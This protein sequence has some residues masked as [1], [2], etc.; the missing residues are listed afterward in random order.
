VL[1]RSTERI[2]QYPACEQNSCAF[3]AP[4][5]RAVDP[6]NHMTTYGIVHNS[7]PAEYPVD[8]DYLKRYGI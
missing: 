6:Q 2:L 1:T 3:G 7:V 8:P 4:V 5:W